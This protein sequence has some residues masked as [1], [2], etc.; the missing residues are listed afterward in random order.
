MS[1]SLKSDIRTEKLT[2]RM[3][4]D[5]KVY[6]SSSQL[7]NLRLEEVLK[8]DSRKVAIFHPVRNEPDISHFITRDNIC[9]PVVVPGSR[10]LLFRRVMA[11]QVLQKNKYGIMQPPEEA[12]SCSPDIVIVPMAA[13]DRKG[14][15]I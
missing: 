7:I 12:E 1:S 5:A 14:H 4:M 13:F 8:P 10:Q 2:L 3:Q 15:R 9:L 11:G 6:T